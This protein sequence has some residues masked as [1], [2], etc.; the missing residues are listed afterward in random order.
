MKTFVCFL[1]FF[2]VFSIAHADM[3]LIS[4]QPDADEIILGY[5]IYIDGLEAPIIVPPKNGDK[6]LFFRLAPEI[7][8]G[9]LHKFVVLAYNAWGQSDASNY[10][11]ITGPPPTP[12]AR[13]I[14]T[15]DLKTYITGKIAPDYKP[16]EVIIAGLSEIDVSVKIFTKDGTWRHEV[17]TQAEG[18][19]DLN[20]FAKNVFGKSKPASFFFE[21]KKPSPAKRLRIYKV[22]E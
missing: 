1:M 6:S 8:D 11:V 10:Q 12:E 21:T 14:L 9:K 4:D 19:Y 18:V 5:K 22:L 17:T 13:L 2:A 3:Y 7:L 16:M 15:D 20:L